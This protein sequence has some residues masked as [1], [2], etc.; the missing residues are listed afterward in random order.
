MFE[1]EVK[2]DYKKEMKQFMDPLVPLSR[3]GNLTNVTPNYALIGVIVL[4]VCCGAFFSGVETAL[5]CC[6]RTRMKTKADNGSKSAKLVWRILEKYDQS[7]I[8]IL[9]GNN[10]LRIASASIATILAVS[11]LPT[12][13]ALA[14]TLSTVVMTLIVFMFGELIPKNIAKAN[15]DKVSQILS[16]PLY[17]IYI[18]TYPLMQI[19]NFILWIFKKIFRMDKGESALSKDEFQGL[20][21]A[22]EDD[23]V[24]DSEEGD[25]IQAAIDFNDIT[26]KTVMTPKEKIVA[27][28]YKQLSREQLLKSLDHIKFTR[29]PVYS[30]HMDNII[31]I[32]NIR[33]F[34]KI[35]MS[36]KKLAIKQSM[37]E[38]ITVSDT[39]PLDDVISLFKT[40]KSHMAIVK[41][42][43]NELI[44]LVTMEDVLEELVGE[45]QMKIKN[46]GGARS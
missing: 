2:K 3:F 29:I 21:E 44:G 27:L 33:K 36:S 26:V 45:T 13:E 30:H 16:Y 22:V 23:G 5:T 34:L 12:N 4:L 38:V 46:I 43:N 11:L 35:V 40:K 10:V 42:E 39:T 41:N 6:N 7:L 28:D 20:V 31:G 32:F 19:F 14:T 1:N 8:T 24:I 37:S 18:L 25:I 15:A 17:L 9:I